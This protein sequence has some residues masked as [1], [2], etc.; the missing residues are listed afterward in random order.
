MKDRRF[1]VAVAADVPPGT[2]DG[3]L[4]GKYGVTNPRLFAVQGGPLALRERHPPVGGFDGPVTS[5][6]EGLP[7]GLHAA[8]TTLR[9][10]RCG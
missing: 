1:E 6:A 3:R 5:A 4:V 10:G 9:W 7:N 2:Y 8:P